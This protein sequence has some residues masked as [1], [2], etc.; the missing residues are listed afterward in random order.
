[1]TRKYG[2]Q[3]D[4]YVQKFGSYLRWYPK[5]FRDDFTEEM[6]QLLRDQLEDAAKSGDEHMVQEVYLQAV[7]ELPGSIL[8]SRLFAPISLGA[9]LESKGISSWRF[10][11]ILYLIATPFAALGMAQIDYLFLPLLVPLLIVG[12]LVTCWRYTGRVSSVVLLIVIGFL[13]MIGS[14]LITGQIGAIKGVS[15]DQAQLLLWILALLIPYVYVAW[16]HLYPQKNARKVIAALS[17]AEQEELREGNAKKRRFVIQT[18]GILVAVF[19]GLNLAGL[20][21]PSVNF[22][23]LT[24]IDNMVAHDQNAYFIL[25]R[26]QLPGEESEKPVLDQIN[27]NI[28]KYVKGDAWND[29]D[30]SATLAAYK[31]TRQ[32]VAD[33]AALSFYQDPATEYTYG[34]MAGLQFGG[35]GWMNYQPAFT[36]VDLDA[37]QQF[38]NGDQEAALTTLSS[39]LR[40]THAMQESNEF[41]ISYVISTSAQSNVLNI[42]KWM[43]KNGLN[44]S[45]KSQVLAMLPSASFLYS[46]E[47]NAWKWEFYVSAMNPPKFGDPSY[48]GIM[49]MPYLYQPNRMIGLRADAFRKLIA[50]IGSCPKSGAL[51]PDMS[52][53]SMFFT[54]NGIGKEFAQTYPESGTATC[55]L[56]SVASQVEQGI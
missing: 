16:L 41:Y 56:L 21:D 52:T 23:D 37:L 14:S 12:L 33:A 49:L 55:D 5:Q 30:V 32:F 3:I 6:L 20:Y 26:M 40:V 44:P 19:I 51:P 25:Q 7:Y 48:G 17:E 31:E 24:P 2:R 11:S 54:Y 28:S 53:F 45:Y 29:A 15:F 9:F 8:I 18:V 42:I 22:D 13:G 10:F 36:L 35:L 50:T 4:G 1:M 46:S 43:E 39:V 38:R 27:P 47:E 34:N